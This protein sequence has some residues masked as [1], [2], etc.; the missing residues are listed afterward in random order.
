MLFAFG[1]SWPVALAVT[2]KGADPSTPLPIS[3]GKGRTSNT[4]KPPATEVLPFLNGS[5]AKPT[6]GSKSFFV[7]F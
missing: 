3:T 6:R 7:G 1:V 4:P 2:S 5:Q